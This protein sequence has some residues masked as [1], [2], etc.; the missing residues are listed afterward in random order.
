MTKPLNTVFLL[1]AHVWRED[2]NHLVSSVLSIY[3]CFASS[4][5]VKRIKMYNVSLKQ[6]VQY[7]CLMTP[8]LFKHGSTPGIFVFLNPIL[9][10]IEL[11]IEMSM[12][13]SERKK[14]QTRQRE[15]GK[16][17]L[18]PFVI[19]ITDSYISQQIQRKTTLKIRE[20]RHYQYFVWVCL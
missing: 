17:S 18:F 7:R 19:F 9:R 15:E 3:I 11:K 5:Y 13:V 12:H 4:I 1:P 14:Q 16:M 8:D 2:I 10:S 20:H 6:N